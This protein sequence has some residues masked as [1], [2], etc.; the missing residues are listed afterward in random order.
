MLFQT[1]ELEVCGANVRFSPPIVMFRD[2]P[3]LLLVAADSTTSR[4]QF[5]AHYSFTPL[6]V[7]SRSRSRSRSI[8]MQ[9]GGTGVAEQGGVL[10][11]GTVCDWDYR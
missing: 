3:A 11:S 1:R 9:G 10:R 6:H 8:A 7:G 2:G 5:L 4:S